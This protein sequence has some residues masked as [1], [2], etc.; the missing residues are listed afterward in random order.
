[1]V[2]H[3]HYPIREPR[4]EREAECLAK[5]NYT[6][7]VLCLRHPF[8]PATE[9]IGNVNIHRLPLRRYKGKGVIVQFF[10]FNFFPFGSYF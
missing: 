7:D 3:A 1:M 10:E 8:E 2:V 4:V 6:V 5:N 9:T